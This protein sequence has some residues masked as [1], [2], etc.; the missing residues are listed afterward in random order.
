MAERK[1]TPSWADEITPWFL[2]IFAALAGLGAVLRAC[3]ATNTRLLEGLD[4]TTLFYL[5]VAGALLLLRQVKSV[6]FGS[7]KLEML[8]KVREKQ[9]QQEDKIEDISLMLPLLLPE[10]ERKHL[11]NLARDQTDNYKGNGALRAELGRLSYLG[12]ITLRPGQHIRYMVD[13][14][15]FDL[16]TYAELTD[17]GQRWTR[18]IQQLEKADPGPEEKSKGAEENS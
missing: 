7:Y 16:A 9:A 14:L 4:H 1:A 11:I 17:L 13:G 2:V 18:R 10:K 3:F 5:G 15:S 12:L 6:S 8:E